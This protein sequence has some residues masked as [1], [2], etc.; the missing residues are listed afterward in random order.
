MVILQ[1][2][3]VYRDIKV[4][5]SFDHL[6]KPQTLIGGVRLQKIESLIN[7]IESFKVLIKEKITKMMKNN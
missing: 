6:K 2:Y 5:L 1:F 3:K 4:I 7:Q